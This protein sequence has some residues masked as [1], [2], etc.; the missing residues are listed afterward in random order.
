M[1]EDLLPEEC[2]GCPDTPGRGLTNFVPPDPVAPMPLLEADLFRPL[3]GPVTGGRRPFHVYLTGVGPVCNSLNEPAA[4]A[5]DG[6][7][8]ERKC[9]WYGNGDA[10]RY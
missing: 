3:T 8:S 1:V 9:R 5:Q 6:P 2:V 10:A 4:T 7:G